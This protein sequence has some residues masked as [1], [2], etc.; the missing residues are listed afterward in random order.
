MSTYKIQ[1]LSS[2]FHSSAMLFVHSI[3]HKEQ[4]IP[5]SLILIQS[6][7]QF[8]WC[9]K[10]NDNEIVGTVAAWKAKEE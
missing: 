5:K 1:L 2:E 9:I 3:F 4:N 10:E 7:E 8:G 6:K